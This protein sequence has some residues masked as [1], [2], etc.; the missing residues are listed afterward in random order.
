[1][2]TREGQCYR[3]VTCERDWS[4][5]KFVNHHESDCRHTIDFSVFA[6]KFANCCRQSRAVMR[7]PCIA[8][9]KLPCKIVCVTFNTIEPDALMNLAVVCNTREGQ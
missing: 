6:E 8:A 5:D 9:T 7:K 2:N 4:Y 3:K 1:V